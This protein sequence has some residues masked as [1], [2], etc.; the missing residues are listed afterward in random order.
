MATGV[1]HVAVHA[2]TVGRDVSPQ[3]A[4]AL[5]SALE[6]EW[7]G[8][9]ARIVDVCGRLY[10]M[11]R[12]Q[13]WERTE[14]A[15]RLYVEGVEDSH[16]TAAEA[17]SA[18][19]AVGVTDEFVEPVVIGDGDGRIAPGDEVV[20]LNFRPDRA[21]QICQ[22]LAE[23]GFAAFGRG[24]FG[25]C[26]LTAMTAYWDGQ[27]G[28]I[29]FEEDRPRDVLADALEAA[30]IRQLHVAETEKYAHVTYFLNGGREA[31]HVG[32]RRV[33]IPSPRDVATYDLRPEM[34]AA[35]VCA[36]VVEAIRGGEFGF[37]VVNFANPDMVGHTGSIPAVIQAVE[38]IDHRLGEVITAVRDVDGIAVVTADHGNAEQMLGPGGDPHTAHTT[39][40]VP[41]MVIGD[42]P[43]LRPE[44]RLAD[45]APTVLD[46]LGVAQPAAMT[47]TSLIVR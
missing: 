34:S 18:S 20:F 4:H 36:V 40:P 11:D 2:I 5:L 31:E 35:A 43:G 6:T 27:P 45:L 38:E 32:E 8:G 30:G 9:P 28:T 1:Q 3:Q 7:A 10:A 25:V 42:C 46:L 22:A 12:D 17:M 13:R 26:S 21:R 37:I 14:R 23:P 39:N 29:A 15:W 33:L 24:E 47:G 16:A 41:V 19:Y 44:G